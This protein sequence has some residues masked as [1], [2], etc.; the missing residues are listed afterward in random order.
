VVFIVAVVM[1]IVWAVRDWRTRFHDMN[2]ERPPRMAWQPRI[3][4]LS[5]GV[6]VIWS[7]LVGGALV[8]TLYSLRT[9][10][11]DGLNNL[12]QIPFALPW[13][14]V[15]I[16][17]I[18]SHE[19]DAWIAAGMGWFNGLLILMF[20]PAWLERRREGT[21]VKRPPDRGYDQHRLTG[22]S[23]D[24]IEFQVVVEPARRLSWSV[25][26]VLPSIWW[27]RLSRDRSWWVT[28]ECADRQIALVKER[29]R[30]LPAA[31]DRMVELHRQL[32]S[33]ALADDRVPRAL[34]R[35]PLLVR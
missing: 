20:L 7:L 22:H 3:T 12:F 27:A 8:A 5:A 29:H 24:G 13:F 4:R 9:E 31:F 33:T 18:W 30:T 10:D 19:T 2:V 1:V 15:P 25:P 26:V 35:T 34:I 6:F 14:L 17:G 11:F 21:P 28:A 16:G 23:R 32:E